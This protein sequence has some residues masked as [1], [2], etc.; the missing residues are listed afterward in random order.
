MRFRRFSERNGYIKVRDKLQI[1]VMDEELTTDIWNAFYE[2]FYKSIANDYVDP[3]NSSTTRGQIFCKLAW[4]ELLGKKVDEIPRSVG[5]IN[6]YQIIQEIKASF[7]NSKWNRKYDFVEFL[8][9]VDHDLFK[10]GIKDKLNECLEQQCSGYR[11]V[12]DTVLQI[13]SNEE[14]VEIEQAINNNDLW[15]PVRKHLEKALYLL[16]DRENPDYPNSIKESISAVE[17]LCKIAVDDPKVKV[18]TAFRTIVGKFGLQPHYADTF[19]KL[20]GFVSNEGGI[21]HA[22]KED[23]RKIPFEEAKFM[24]VIC[25]AFTNYMK[26][27]IDEIQTV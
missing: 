7:I 22:L 9:F 11:V 13:T 18:G 5:G 26:S 27:K 16:S 20:F 4:K 15:E 14:I 10:V 3:L 21:R 12:N 24:L 23:D 8:V 6:Y 19:S 1:E 2:D 25:S 17:S